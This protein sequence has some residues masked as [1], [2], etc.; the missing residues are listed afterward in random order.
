MAMSAMRILVISPTAVPG[1]E[2]R[3][4]QL[5][6]ELIDRGHD[7]VHAGPTD[8]LERHGFTQIPFSPDFADRPE[9]RACNTRLFATWEELA[10]L[11]IWSDVVVMGTAKGYRTV[12][13]Y[14]RKNDRILI[15]N[16]DT[17]G[18]DQ[19]TYNA[20]LVCARSTWGRD[21][22]VALGSF[23]PEDIHVTG[24]VQFDRAVA[25]PRLSRDGFCRKYGCDPDKPVAVF[26][27][28]DPGGHFDHYKNYYKKVC[29][30]VNDCCEIK[31]L[32]KPHPREYGRNKQ[33]FHYENTTIPTWEQLAPGIPACESEDAY[34][35]FHHGDVFI[36]R[37]SSSV[38]E[39]A[40]FGKPA[41]VVDAPEFWLR[42]GEDYDYFKKNFPGP[43]FSPP[44]RKSWLPMGVM[45]D[46]IDEI[47]DENIRKRTREIHY[48]L[49]RMYGWTPFEF[50]GSECTLEELPD[51]LDSKKYEFT[52]SRI[53]NDYVERYCHHSDGKAYQRVADV[54]SGVAQHPALRERLE[55]C[56]AGRR[57]QQVKHLVTATVQRARRATRGIRQLMA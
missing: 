52:D 6:R 49:L 51:I 32:I 21:V 10:K 38:I 15:Q 28:T 37:A 9:A 5:V 35:C 23:A 34:E 33:H 42:P 56:R 19:F 7:V 13:D 3:N 48:R 16:D 24:C 57:R 25:P 50:I 43:R 22:L 2:Q 39:L 41:L 54:V 44:G 29:R 55:R 20:D 30:I 45:T 14:A 12:M 11:V 18:I 4:L 17:G 36:T 26:M 40:M 1:H 31:L 46:L 47:S 53:F 27:S 8:G